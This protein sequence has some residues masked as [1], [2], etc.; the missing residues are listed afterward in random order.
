MRKMI[1]IRNISKIT[2][3]ACLVLGLSSCSD[4]STSGQKL[5]CASGTA[6]GGICCENTCCNKTC[7][8]MKTD[9]ENCGACAN[10]CGSG[11]ICHAGLCIVAGSQCTGSQKWCDGVCVN[12]G[13]SV[14]HCGE[15]N[16]ACEEN[17]SCSEGSCVVAC[18]PGLIYCDDL[19]VNA[20]SDADHCGACGHACGD[21]AYCVQS[22]CVCV[23]GTFDCDNDMANGC[24]STSACPLTCADPSLLMC[25]SSCCN[26]GCCDKTG[27]ACCAGSCCDGA[28]R[29]T[30][31]NPLSCGGCD[32]V[33]DTTQVCENGVCVASPI[34]P[35]SC[36]AENKVLCYG[37]CM[38]TQN[39]FSN[40]GACLNVCGVRDICL[41]GVCTPADEDTCPEDGDISCYGACIDARSNYANCGDCDN[42]CGVRDVCVAGACVPADEDTCPQEGTASCNGVCI[43]VQNDKTNC[44][45]CN[46][47][48]ASDEQCEAG[49]CKKIDGIVCPDS[50]WRVCYGKCIDVQN[51]PRNC[52][53]CLQQCGDREACIA[54][55]CE[56]DCGSETKCD[57][58]CV[59]TANN[60]RH[61]GACDISCLAGETCAG[62]TCVC[63]PGFYDCDGLAANGCESSVACNCTPGATESCWRGKPEQRNVGICRDG[64]RICDASGRFWGPCTGG[65]YPSD[66]TCSDQ[67]ILNGLDNNCDGVVD[68]ICKTRCD[69]MAG[70]MSYIGCE[71]W[72]VYL[73]NND[74]TTA[75]SDLTLVISNPNNETA[76][77]YVYDKNAYAAK[78]P[79]YTY[80]VL[81]QQVSLRMIAGQDAASIAKYMASGTELAAKA[82]YVRSSLPIV[83]YQFNP[84]GK[85]AGNTADAS[86]LMPAGVLGK[87][88][89]TLSYQNWYGTSSGASASDVIN[90]VAINPGSTTVKVRP[91]AAIRAGT[92]IAAIA[93]NAER[94]FTMQQ[95]DVLSLMQSV[96]NGESTGSLIEADQKVAVFAGSSCSQIPIGYTACDHT[97]E[98]MIPLQAWGK[99]YAAIKGR[100]LK[101]DDLDIWY[102]L[103]QLD[104]TK[105]SL[106]N[107]IGDAALNADI[108]LNAGAFHKVTTRTNFD[109]TA[110]KPILVGQFL[111]GMNYPSAKPMGDP[112]SILTVPREQ[113]RED[114]IFSVPPGYTADYVTII[115]PKGNTIRYTGPARNGITY[116]S[117]VVDTM[118]AAVFEGWREFGNQGYVFTYL[119]VAGGTHRLVGDQPFG[120]IGYGFYGYTSYGYPAGLDLKIINSN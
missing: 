89:M 27:T 54:G 30:S 75:R 74:R 80:D 106:R 94:T 96:A 16:N 44:G 8:D 21:N 88:Y 73:E 79:L 19:C 11:E 114:Y 34:D 49:K 12:A 32:T 23:K 43:D 29:D 14:Q 91:K 108:T 41:E 7:A 69:L 99:N 117:A 60:V 22:Q 17:E 20:R 2:V 40:C 104:N 33:C 4:D 55:R 120:V 28:C 1:P 98:M 48:C 78:T 86:L 59:N 13:T 9:S 38:D 95:F 51:D 107:N 118:P 24:E 66:I 63:A 83:V 31:D 3:L 97:E 18:A 105:V 52:G 65:T 76:R 50:S 93:A 25:G 26:G 87:D 10:A 58:A 56:L 36:V 77:I 82:F 62:S 119:A 46:K 15:C 5:V 92:G 101:A 45:D 42:R 111:T 102:I 39:D 84:Y 116:S 53:D 57:G 67:G 100:P 81:P 70:E 6:C 37:K 115:S 103:A 61:C 47:K 35:E 64:S 90:I 85:A 109:V 71:Y 112:S 72:P 113:Y 110:D 68:T